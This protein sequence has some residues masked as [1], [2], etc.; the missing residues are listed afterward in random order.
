[1]K[2]YNTKED[3][4]VYDREGKEFYYRYL[5]R[6]REIWCQIHRSVL[7]G[8]LIREGRELPE[9]RDT[10][11]WVEEVCTVDRVKEQCFDP[12]GFTDGGKTLVILPA[13]YRN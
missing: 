7:L 12:Q 8:K 5:D 3:G 9:A 6:G 13:I 1:M 4:I 10:V 2:T 11:N